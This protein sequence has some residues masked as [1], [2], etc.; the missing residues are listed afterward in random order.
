MRTVLGQNATL[1]LGLAPMPETVVESG[2]RALRDR[3][4]VEIGNTM[5]A[6][7]LLTNLPAT[8]PNGFCATEAHLNQRGAEVFTRLLAD[9]I[10]Q[11]LDADPKGEKKP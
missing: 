9:T 4:L 7:I 2:Y 3:M 10:A 5:G 1:Y 6:D 8:M 11:H